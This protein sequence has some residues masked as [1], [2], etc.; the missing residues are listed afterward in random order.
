M[1]IAYISNTAR[2]DPVDDNRSMRMYQLYV[3]RLVPCLV[4]RASAQARAL[5]CVC[6]SARLGHSMISVHVRAVLCIPLTVPK[7]AT[8]PS[9][10]RNTSRLCARSDLYISI[11]VNKE[12]TSTFVS[13]SRNERRC[14]FKIHAESSRTNDR[15]LN[16]SLCN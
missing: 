8:T 15:I 2:S 11:Y 16:R 14:I 1:Y 6:V 9:H 7:A 3:S 12:I 5:A 10:R 13:T 4:T